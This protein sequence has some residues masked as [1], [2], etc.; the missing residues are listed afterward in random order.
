MLL[1][2][3]VLLAAALLCRAAGFEIFP[4][5]VG[6]SN[7]SYLDTMSSNQRGLFVYAMEGLDANFAPPFIFN[8]PRYSAW[9]AVGLL[10]RNEGDD[11][12]I[13][14]Q[15]IRDVVAAQFK[16]P[17]QLWFGTYRSN[18][19]V[20]DPGDVYPPKLYTSYDSNMGLFVCTSWIIAVEEF[21]DLIQA[22]V[23]S[24]MK[25][26]MYNATVGD[27]YRVGGFNGDNLY[28]IYS[29]PW[30]MR[31]MAA[32]YVGNMMD[33]SNM[34]HWGDVW[35]QEAIT[36]FDEYSTLSEF[37]SGTY[38]GVTLYALSLWGYMPA[39]STIASR[40][41]DIITKT[42]DTLSSFY[43]PTLHTLGAPWD[44]AYGCSL[45][46]PTRATDCAPA[47]G[48]NLHGYD[49]RTYFGILGVQIAGLVGGINDGTAPLPNPLVGSE[50]YGDAAAVA[51]T[52]LTAKFND[53]YVS[54]EALTRL[55]TL[56]EPHASFAQAVSP[57]SDNPAYP[58]NYTSWN[59][60]GL[61]VGGMEIDA[62][63]V[64]GPAANRRVGCL[65]ASYPTSSSISAIATSTNLTVSYP[66]SQAFPDDATSSN[67]MAFLFS[68]I[69]GV[70]LPA[71]FWRMATFV[72]GSG[73]INDVSYYNLTY[74]IPE[75]GAEEEARI[76]FGFEKV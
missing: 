56:T 20:P 43:N 45:S 8:S 35:A 33:D 31:V 6:R 53:P 11:V 68:G 19:N 36:A 23:L 39:N 10:A 76:V 72:Y 30:Y 7:S 55:K 26:S 46:E 38:S 67:V 57:P 50:H 64:G 65:D 44:R 4:G 51:L 41:P 70:S 54:A 22:D 74:T 71:T 59:E 37:N 49:M 21:S 29:N 32:T 47:R 62:K 2:P 58:R 14:N 48:A 60:A 16:D 15:I 9:Y 28:P 18:P 12:A 63:V 42:W 27:G 1:L 3:V 73:S 25:S 52:P 24:L 69:A 61:S 75:L 66:A 17:T 40:A 5:I 13:A 34:T